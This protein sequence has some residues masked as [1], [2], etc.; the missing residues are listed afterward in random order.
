MKPRDRLEIV[1]SGGIPDRVPHMELNFLIPEQ[2]FGMAWPTEEEVRKA[3]PAERE[4]LLERMFDLWERIIER[5]HWCG[6]RMPYDLHGF[7]RGIVIPRG[8]RRFGDEVM[9]WSP[10][11]MGTFWMPNGAN[12]MEFTELLYCRPAEAHGLARKKRDA[13]IDLAKRQLDGGAD[14]IMINSD[15]AY[16]QGPFISPAM[17]AE[18]V[19]PYLAEIVGKIHDFG[20]RAMLHSDG[21]M[22]LILDQVV[23]AGIDGYQSIDPQGNMDI[24]E[25]KRLYGDRLVL[26]GNVQSSFLQDAEEERIRESARYCMTHG[27]P[28]GRYIF[29]SSNVLFPGMPL[30][31][32]HIMLEEYEKL[33][34]Y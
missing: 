22:R 10:N 20:G 23:A 21:D 15:Y 33:A 16:N 14:F 18:F 8:A 32:Y 30:E 1:F 25:V 5:Y 9:I 12:M 29:S 2:A 4:G 3:T 24:A 26:M 13:S 28:G 11:G 34:G 19:A 7:F 27:K 6:I 17:F 31:S